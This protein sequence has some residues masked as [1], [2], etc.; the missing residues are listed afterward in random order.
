MHPDTPESRPGASGI[1]QDSSIFK[2]KIKLGKG[3]SIAS[4]NSIQGAN[5]IGDITQE[6]SHFEDDIE[7]DESVKVNLGNEINGKN[8]EVANYNSMMGNSNCLSD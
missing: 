2:S 8:Q 3:V 7:G 5:A 6:G 1:R 4:G